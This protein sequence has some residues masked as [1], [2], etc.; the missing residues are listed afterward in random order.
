V[1][2][3]VPQRLLDLPRQQLAI[4]AEISFESVAINDDPAS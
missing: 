4:M 3:L 2:Q 1:G